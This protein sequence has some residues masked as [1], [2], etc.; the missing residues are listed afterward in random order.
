MVL[1]DK[2]VHHIYIVEFSC[3]F[4]I[5]IVKK[6]AEKVGKYQPLA[7]EMG[8]LY[9][10][11]RVMLRPLIFGARGAIHVD[12]VKFLRSIP[13]CDKDCEIL[14][15]IMQKAVLLGTLHLTRS[16]LSTE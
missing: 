10:T 4:D 9:P 8:H 14:L 2:V 12:T 1:F 15:V 6:H 16:F 3:P 13:T 7:V 11:W 5:N